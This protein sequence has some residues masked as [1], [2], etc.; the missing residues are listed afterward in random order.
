MLSAS[1]V[2]SFV[3]DGYIT[4]RGAVQHI[5]NVPRSGARRLHRVRQALRGARSGPHLY[6]AG[7]LWSGR[8]AAW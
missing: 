6:G 1:E 7:S 2:E 8:S 3:A 4:M 5:A